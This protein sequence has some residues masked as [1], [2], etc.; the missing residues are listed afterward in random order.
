MHNEHDDDELYQVSQA[1]ASK[2]EEERERRRERE[3]REGEQLNKLPHKTKIKSHQ[4]LRF[5]H[6]LYLY[7]HK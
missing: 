3:E 6:E 1:K 2:G 7:L 5:S 4:V